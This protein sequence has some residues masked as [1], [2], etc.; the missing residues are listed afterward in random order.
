MY[1]PVEDIATAVKFVTE[2]VPDGV[3]PFIDT[4]VR[5]VICD[6]LR[7][8]FCDIYRLLLVIAI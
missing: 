8:K 4:I 1:W 6:Q 7:P 2:V 5:L 3:I